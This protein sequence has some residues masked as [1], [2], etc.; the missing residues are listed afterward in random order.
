MIYAIRC[1]KPGF[2]SV[3]FEAGLNL[4][5]ADRLA[6]SS[7]TDTRNGVGKTSLI[8]ILHHCL[9]GSLGSGTTLGRLAQRDESYVFT[10][11]VNVGGDRVTFSRGIAAK[12]I[13]VAGLSRVDAIA[14]GFEETLDGSFQTDEKGVSAYL[15]PRWFGLAPRDSGP[16]PPSFRTLLLFFARYESQSYAD[17]FKAFVNMPART[18][19]AC[20]AFL[21]SL[22]WEYVV[23]LEAIDKE[24]GLARA[25]VKRLSDKGQGASRL[26]SELNDLE[27]RRDHFQRELNGFRVLENFASLRR[28]ADEVTR[29]L[30]EV[31]DERFQD[32]QLL[33]MYE[34]ELPVE[35]VAD[36]PALADLYAEVEF[37]FPER[38][39]RSLEEVRNFHA[40]VESNRKKRLFEAVLAVQARLDRAAERERELDEERSRLLSELSAG[41]ALE[42]L[43]VLQNRL[44]EIGGQIE[45]RR[46]RVA[47]ILGAE[48]RELDLERDRSDLAAKAYGDHIE[49]A[50]MRRQ[51]QTLFSGYIR[52]LYDRDGSLDMDYTPKDGY[53]FRVHCP[54]D[55]AEGVERMLVFCYDLTLAVLWSVHQTSPGFLIH[56]TTLFDA[57]EER[58]RRIALDLAREESERCG[59][60]YITFWNTDAIP[61]QAL[62]HEYERYVRLR[63]DD[64]P[65][66]SL[67]GFHFD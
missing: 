54:R 66:G 45:F 47:E 50:S 41:G 61:A 51:A 22:G 67:F 6:V 4:V 2:K 36:I 21:L 10:V 26:E 30:G 34:A 27:L 16:K 28:D 18:V 40:Q 24:L 7:P 17:A 56:D 8:S 62:D 65:S 19:R 53:R 29:R 44:G 1:D 63:L 43:N 37:F 23:E 14:Y 33:E 57:V 13:R 3:E 64:T 25:E 11:V 58:Q 42:E 48:Q 32:R 59:F 49:R 20:A 38:V 60:Q 15:G 55:G 52:K 39:R 31:R 9:G 46:Q 35:S 12:E 5:V